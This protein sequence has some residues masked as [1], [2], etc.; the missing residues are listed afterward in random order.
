MLLCLVHNQSQPYCEQYF[1]LCYWIGLSENFIILPGNPTISDA[2]QFH[3]DEEG[4]DLPEDFP[5]FTLTCLYTGDP[6]TT[7]TWKRDGTAVTEDSNHIMSHTLVGQSG[8][9]YTNTLTVTGSEDGLYTCTVTNDIGSA[10][11][12]YQV[13]GKHSYGYTVKNVLLLLL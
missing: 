5:V 3:L 12:Q 9:N 6:A 2:I 1:Y 11:R 10:D 7:V 13:E 4:I 8:S